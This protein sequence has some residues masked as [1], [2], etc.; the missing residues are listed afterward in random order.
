MWVWMG[1][2]VV[3]AVFAGGLADEGEGG[4]VGGVFDACALGLAGGLGWGCGVC[5]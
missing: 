3:D 1:E 2:G 5:G 4:V